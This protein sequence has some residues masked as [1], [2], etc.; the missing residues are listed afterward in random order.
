[1]HGNL[2]GA[3]KRGLSSA[4]NTRGRTTVP[5]QILP[6]TALLTL[7]Q[8]LKLKAFSASLKT[9]WMQTNELVNISVCILHL[10][11]FSNVNCR[12]I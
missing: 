7:L 9:V 10:Q 11:T 1:M 2:E 5:K 6:P 12:F 3:E 8:Q 4:T